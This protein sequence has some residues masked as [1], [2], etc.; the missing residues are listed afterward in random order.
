MKITMST[1][2]RSA[3]HWAPLILRAIVG[4]GFMAHGYAKLARGPQ[5][6][7]VTLEALGVPIPH[8]LAWATVLV[9]LLGG[10]AVFLGAFVT[11]VSVP[12]AVVLVVAMF[13]VHLRYGFSSIKLMAV[14]A[15]GPQ[16]GPPGYECDLLYLACLAALVVGGSGPLAID[17][18]FRK[19]PRVKELSHEHRG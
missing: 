6:F 15:A 2:R 1:S 9:E 11:I 3:S 18:L 7:G 14:T 4:Y 19:Q 17:Q 13:T 12:M 5:V 16:F 8:I 10:L